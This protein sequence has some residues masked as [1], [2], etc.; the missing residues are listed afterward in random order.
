MNNFEKACK[1]LTDILKGDP[2]R[3]KNPLSRQAV[4]DIYSEVYP[5]LNGSNCSPSDICWN[6]ANGHQMT[7]D[8]QHWPH[9]LEYFDGDYKVIGSDVKYTGTVYYRPRGDKKDSVFGTYVNGIFHEGA[10]AL[11]E[12][13][14]DKMICS[15]RDDLIEGLRQKLKDMPVSVSFESN[16]VLVKFQEILICGVSV[17][18]KSYCI[19][20]VSSEW[21][22]KT[23]YLCDEAGN[24][25]WFYYLETIDE[26]IGECYRL[27][28]FEARKD[29]HKPSVKHT[30]EL[31]RIFTAESF[32][33]AYSM[34]LEQA[35]KNAISQKAQGSTIPFGVS[36]PISDGFA[37]TQHFGQGVA[38]K[39][40]Y[41]NW[42][43]VSIYYIV[44][45]AR[46]VMG[47]ETER[48]PHLNQMK[49][50]KY[51]QFGNRKASIAVFYES[52]KAE[53]NYAELYERFIDV[54]EEVMRLDVKY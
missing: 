53:I 39:T 14:I 36:A 29:S 13:Q 20:N 7:K 1:V 34:F 32:E 17:E 38:G 6:R 33:K 47:I 2:N 9:A 28:F 52:A 25:T 24:D 8:F 42:H 49:P 16:K 51:E 21:A 23:S 46:I 19:Y 4:I 3:I 22:D 50:L 5:E 18:D 12:V 54:S 40:P 37:L 35:D 45:E 48:Y 15:R 10:E 44:D 27:V 30:S 26:C 43:V 31:S 41:L 11:N